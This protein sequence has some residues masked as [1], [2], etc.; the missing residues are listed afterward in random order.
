M[1]YIDCLL[2]YAGKSKR[3]GDLFK[4]ASSMINNTKKFLN[5]MFGEDVKNVLLQHKSWLTGSVLEQF[6]KGKLD[7]MQYPFFSDT[8][9]DGYDAQI[10]STSS[11]KTLII[12]MVGGVTYEEAKEIALFGKQPTA[13]QGPGQGQLQQMAGSALSNLGT[14]Q[15]QQ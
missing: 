9:E 10:S 3:K 14:A 7:Q 15:N 1:S 12:F 13:S 8:G 11:C 4:E 6:S 2:E 5:S